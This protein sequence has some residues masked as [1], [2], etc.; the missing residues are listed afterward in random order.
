MTIGLFKQFLEVGARTFINC[1]EFTNCPKV[2]KTDKFCK[3]LFD[4]M[5]EVSPIKMDS[6]KVRP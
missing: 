6:E 1:P 3:R 5:N 2:G 4:A